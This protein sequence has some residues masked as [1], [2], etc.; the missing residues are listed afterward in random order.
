[1]FHRIPAL[2]TAAA[3]TMQ[4]SAAA[5]L[6]EVDFFTL[7]NGRDEVAAVTLRP[8]AIKYRGSSA[9]PAPAPV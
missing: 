7:Q 6:R 5:L 2:V 3:H 9:R 1:M 4:G 8:S